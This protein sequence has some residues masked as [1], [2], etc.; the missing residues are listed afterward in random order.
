MSVL[1]SQF[2]PPSNS[3]FPLVIISCFSMSVGLFLFCRKVYLCLSLDSTYKWYHMLLYLSPTSLSTV[4]SRSIHVA[5]NDSILSFFYSFYDSSFI[6][7][8]CHIFIHSSVNRHLGCFHVSA[9][10]NST[11]V[12]IGVNVYFQIMLFSRYIP[13]SKAA[14][15]KKAG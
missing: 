13:R 14:G 11:A 6:V 8:I 10:V 1:I 4:I 9:V 12:N 3:L 15:A 2:I 5:A 7:Y